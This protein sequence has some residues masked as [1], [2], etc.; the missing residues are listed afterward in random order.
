[1]NFIEHFLVTHWSVEID[2]SLLELQPG[3]F[4]LYHKYV[5]VLES[6]I[7]WVNHCIE[8]LA[9]DYLLLEDAQVC[10]RNI[11]NQFVAFHPFQKEQVKY[12][13]GLRLRQTNCE[14][15]QKELA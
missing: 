11:K 12:F 1:M 7:R 4:D 5:L 15:G 13:K 10:K 3:S 2:V 9:L 8:V 6:N 14:Q